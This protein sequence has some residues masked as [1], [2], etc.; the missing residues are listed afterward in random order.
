MVPSD[1]ARWLFQYNWTHETLLQCRSLAMSTGDKQK[2][3][4]IEEDVAF[5]P[6]QKKMCLVN[7]RDADLYVFKLHD[8]N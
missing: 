3:L 6:D 1:Q 8:N 7:E 5:D 4:Y 2:L